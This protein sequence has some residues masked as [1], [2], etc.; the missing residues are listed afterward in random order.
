MRT[1]HAIDINGQAAPEKLTDS[2]ILKAS[3]ERPAL[4]AQL[5][6]R[7]QVPFMRKAAAF[8]GDEEDARDAVQETFVRIYSAAKRFRAKEGASFASWA[9]AILIN[10]CRTAYRKAQRA[11]LSV[12]LDGDGELADVIPDREELE[13]AESR[14]S[15]EYLM[16]MLSRLPEIMRR[17]VSL[18]FLEGLSEKEVARR[19]GVSHGVIRTRIY[20]AKKRLRAM[21]SRME[22]GLAPEGIGSR[23]PLLVPIAKT[24]E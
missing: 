23:S 10:Q 19:E 20:R 2:D 9:Y 8:L 14:L 7:Y 18:H 11:E 24:H 12:S 4:F 17:A 16:S 6:E 5:V 21:A 15:A 13:R 1:H 22:L 3:L